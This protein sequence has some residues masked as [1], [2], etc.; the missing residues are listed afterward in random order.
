MR[1]PWNA[2]A[3]VDGATRDRACYLEAGNSAPSSRM[4]GLVRSAVQAITTR[5]PSDLDQGTC[6]ESPAAGAGRTEPGW[7]GK[8]ADRSDLLRRGRSP[9]G[10][11]VLSRP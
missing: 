3:R 5:F 2:V 11:T 7:S 8:D 6:A 1:Q 9:L 10:R 4:V